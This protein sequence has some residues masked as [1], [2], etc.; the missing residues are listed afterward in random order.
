M[1]RRLFRDEGASA[2]EYGLLLAGIA[3]L[4]VAA[5]FLVGRS[6]A[7]NFDEACDAILSEQG[8]TC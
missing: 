7:A 1:R 2:V 8:G 6:N 4:I 5:V 3:A